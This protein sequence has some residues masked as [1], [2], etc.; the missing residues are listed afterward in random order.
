M[1]LEV[2]FELLRKRLVSLSDEVDELGINAMQFF[3]PVS[4]D[5]QANGDDQGQR[6][7]SPVESLGENALALKGDL[8]E[9]MTALEKGLTAIRPPRNLQQAQA[10]LIDVN[11]YLN[12][13]VSRCRTDVSA[14][15][16]LQVLSE[17]A[18]ELGGGWPE[19]LTLVHKII[20]TVSDKFLETWQALCQCWEE[21]A[22]KLSAGA[23][24]VQTTNIGQHIT[25]HEDEL[26]LTAKA[27]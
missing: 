7:P 13:A 15:R 6:A 1:S 3:P 21:L 4:S 18:K 20:R 11:R 17:I 24:S 10:S 27:T 9:A 14:A 25:M 16:T 26:E 12:D 2:A 5:D 8:H 22:E 19:W 23:V